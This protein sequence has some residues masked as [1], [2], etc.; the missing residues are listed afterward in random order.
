MNSVINV[1]EASDNL[2]YLPVKMIIG[3]KMKTR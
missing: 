1:Y 2:K 3:T